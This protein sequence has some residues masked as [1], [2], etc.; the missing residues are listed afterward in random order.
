MFAID[1]TTGQLKTNGALNHETKATYT[2]NV[3]VADGSGTDTISVTINV[4][5]VNEAPVIAA[6]TDATR[7]VAE[8]TAAGENIGSAIT[9]TDEDDGDTLT[10]TLGGTDAE[11]V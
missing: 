2:V 4:T 6:D 8:D 11:V 1:N 9:A 5:D 7:F 3:V 10:W